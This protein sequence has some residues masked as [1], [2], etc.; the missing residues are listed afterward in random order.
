[1]LEQLWYG[2]AMQASLHRLIEREARVVGAVVLPAWFAFWSVAWLRLSFSSGVVVG[3]DTAIYRAGAAAWLAGGDPWKA[4]VNYPHGVLSYAGLPTTTVLSA[5][6]AIVPRE[7][8]VAVM[9]AVSF[10]SALAIIRSLKLPW[11][12]LAFPPLV[13]GVTA[14]NPQIL[15]TAL[16]LRSNRIGRAVAVLLKG[17]PIFPLLGELDWRA[18]VLSVG[19][20]MVSLV[21][22]A[23]LWIT[24]LN[25]WPLIT[26][27]LITE[28]LGG[29]S[30][31][32]TTA[33]PLALVAIG[34]L[35]V[36]DHRAAGWLA[37]V[38]LW[39]ATEPH[40]GT[41]A[42]PFLRRGLLAAVIALPIAGVP[43]LAVMGYTVSL[44]W[45]RVV[46]HHDETTLT[47]DDHPA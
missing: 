25:E 43:A 38:A 46:R 31:Y 36:I 1:M 19:A 24:Y 40:Y 34:I 47:S 42:M 13:I 3:L 45:Q 6:L 7:V 39:P 9:M 44:L 33:F 32:G 12:W 27:R 14:A 2:D 29:L 37:P 35:A 11:W 30:A 20:A 28:S 8:A 17:Y 22:V 18:I 10:A 4:H 15:I 16:L 23:P 21:L 26:S 41:F 5:P